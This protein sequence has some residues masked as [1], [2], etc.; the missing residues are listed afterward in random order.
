MFG[1][2]AYQLATYHGLFS[3][4]RAGSVVAGTALVLA[5]VVAGGR[6]STGLRRTGSR[7]GAAFACYLGTIGVATI[8]GYGLNGGLDTAAMPIVRYALFVLLIPVAILGAYLA[9]EPVAPIR[10]VVVGLM[11]V[12][13]AW[14]ATDAVRVAREFVRSPPANPHRELADYLVS[15]GIRYARGGYWDAY[16]VTFLAREQVIVAST[17]QVR[18]S[19]YEALVDQHAAEAVTLVRQPC[20]GERRVS[21]WCLE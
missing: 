10:A 7:T 21:V 3:E 1:A 2:R 9:R 8:V 4:L 13:A 18:I 20:E 6:L 19:A 12:W 14:T 15:H 5:L 16:V 11:C 17:E